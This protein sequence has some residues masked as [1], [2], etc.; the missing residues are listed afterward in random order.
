M[1]VT[2]TA[3]WLSCVPEIYIVCPLTAHAYSRRRGPPPVRRWAIDLE[4]RLD[5]LLAY[6]AGAAAARV[7][8]AVDV[9]FALEES[10]GEGR[11]GDGG[12]AG[13]GGLM[14]V[15]SS[16]SHTLDD[17]ALAAVRALPSLP[18]PP[19]QLRGRRVL[20]RARFGEPALA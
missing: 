10:A 6:P 8:G 12:E 3:A 16:G 18:A 13:A 4:H 2:S 19:E 11:E 7:C 20:M 1:A 14:L 9:E 15:R 5:R 17:A